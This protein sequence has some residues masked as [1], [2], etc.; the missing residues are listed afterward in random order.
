MDARDPTVAVDDKTCRQCFYTA[1]QLRKLFG[2]KHHPVVHLH[3]AHEGLHRVPSGFIH[4]DADYSEAFVF[5][6]ALHIDKPRNL[7]ATWS[8]PCGP[9]VEQNHLSLEV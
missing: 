4:G 9:E 8:A 3:V 5:E 7:N 1:V 6:L 2:A